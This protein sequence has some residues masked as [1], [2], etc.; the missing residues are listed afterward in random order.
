MFQVYVKDK[1][2]VKCPIKF[3]LTNTSKLVLR[4]GGET[5]WYWLELNLFSF[6]DS[7]MSNKSWAAAVSTFFSY[8]S[9]L[10][11]ILRGM[12]VLTLSPDQR[13]TVI[14]KIVTCT[15]N[16]SCWHTC[17]NPCF[18]DAVFCMCRCYEVHY[19][20]EC[21]CIRCCSFAVPCSLLWLCHG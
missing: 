17:R 11:S 12:L 4:K 3:A 18:T 13:L 21:Y 15:V 8:I 10:Q 9:S 16:C 20:C 2:C 19:C 6:L 1:C 7:N 14:D 5:H